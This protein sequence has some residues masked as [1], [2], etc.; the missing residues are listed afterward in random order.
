MV[1]LDC[2]G[3]FVNFLSTR[4][5]TRGGRLM[6]PDEQRRSLKA[7][8][9]VRIIPGAD[10]G[11]LEFYATDT[12]KPFLAKPVRGRIHDGSIGEA[13]P[14]S[15]LGCKPPQAAQAAKDW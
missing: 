7:H 15:E 1:D 14:M 8:C 12:W 11:C 9:A 6:R 4:K 10:S 3:D 2:V 5:Y 13:L